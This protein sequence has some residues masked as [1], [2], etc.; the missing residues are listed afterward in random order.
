MELE[1]DIVSGKNGEVDFAVKIE[2]G[3]LLLE[4]GYIGSGAGAGIKV[5]LEAD[6]FLDKLKNAIPGQLDDSVIDLIKVAVKA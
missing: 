6:Y 3:I 5:T 1:M 2:K 4:V